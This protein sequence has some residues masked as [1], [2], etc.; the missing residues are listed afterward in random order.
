M[1]EINL[2]MFR[3]SNFRILDGGLTGRDEA[4]HADSAGVGRAAEVVCPFSVP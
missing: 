2:L 4:S 3:P 1:I